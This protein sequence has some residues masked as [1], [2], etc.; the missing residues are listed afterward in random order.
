MKEINSDEVLGFYRNALNERQLEAVCYC[1]GPSLVIAGAGSGKTRVLTYKIA[2]LIQQG[3]LPWNILALTFTNKAAQEMNQRISEIVGTE[4]T[5][6]LWSGTFHSVF[7]KIL[8]IEAEVIGYRADF[9]IYDAADSK[10]LI[11]SIVKEM[12]LDDKKYKSSL[13]ASRISEAKNLLIRPEHY[14]ADGSLYKR[15]HLDGVGEIR[16][17]YRRYAIRLQQSNAMDFDDLLLNTYLLLF[18][19]EEIRDKYQQRFKYI[20]VDEYQDTN[21]AQHRI[22]S[23][24]TKSDSKICVVG[25]DAQSIYGFRGANID[26]ILQFTRQYPTARVIKLERNYRSTQT[27]V[28]AANC[29]ISHNRNQI[30]KSVYSEN[31][32]GDCL[33]LITSY[34]DKEE[35]LKVVAEVK[36]LCHFK[37]LDYNEVAL[38]YRTNAQS[39]LFEEAFRNA[40]V[41]YRIYG[42]L[43]F[44]QRK[45]IKDTIAY[46]RLVANLNDEEAYRRIINYPARGIGKTTQDKLMATAIEKGV[47]VWQVLTNCSYYGLNFTKGTASK[48]QNFVQLILNFR[49]KLQHVSSYALAAE[50]I[51]ESG[52]GADIHIDKSP[53]NLSKQENVEELLNS[54]KAYEME[55]LEENGRSFV[56]LTEYLSQ[57]SLLSDTETDDDKDSKVTLM[58]V[59]AAKGLEFDAVFITGMEDDLFPNANARY[60]PKEMEEE[61]RL[62]YVAV[63]RAKRYCF[64]SY[65][66]SRMRFGA[67]EFS[68]PSPFLDEIESQYFQNNSHSPI[69]ASS[70][71]SSTTSTSSRWKPIRQSPSSVHTMNRSAVQS[72]TVSSVPTTPSS[73]SL[74]VGCQVE[75]ERFGCGVVVS[76]EGGGDNAKAC[77][78]FQNAGKKF[79]L[80]KFAKL[81]VVKE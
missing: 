10:S 69:S 56:P 35:S 62:F 53:E 55:Q 14:A 70:F 52:I 48:L 42:G 71:P 26:N 7:A 2:Y 50:I 41:P 81:K 63:T 36:R 12:G 39:R 28:N 11:K 16:E 17:I 27:I 61:R 43:S 60:Y 15:D 46:F 6:Q 1:D 58:T 4:Y 30:R 22:V 80:L 8:R 20:L 57:V 3:Y 77:V 38:L 25:D 13:V 76:L 75:H 44:Y 29:I 21:I 65:A 23:L 54:M 66:K 33:K 64:L 9:T 79:L 67:I 51:R 31:E 68:N 34:S 40:D 19:H 49:E 32:V 45:E 74:S 18:N 59:H 24:L 47:P 72:T 73:S 37:Q 78:E 5:R